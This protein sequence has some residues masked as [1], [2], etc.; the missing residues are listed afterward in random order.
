MRDI[1]SIDDF[2]IKLYFMSLDVHSEAIKFVYC[3]NKC[4]VIVQFGSVQLCEFTLCEEKVM[5]SY[6]LLFSINSYSNIRISIR[7]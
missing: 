3:D 4:S 7:K 5:I 2:M 6:D 1:K